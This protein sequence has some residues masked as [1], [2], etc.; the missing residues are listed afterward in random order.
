[1]HPKT[2]KIFAITLAL[3]IIS[4]VAV[5]VFYYIITN[6]AVKLEEQQKIL[7]ENI[8]KESIH[9]RTSHLID[10]T[11]NERA[12][13]ASYYFKNEGDSIDLLGRIENLARELGISLK[14]EALDKIVTKDKKEFIKMSFAFEGKKDLV[15]NFAELFEVLPYHI[16]VENLKLQQQDSGNWV[17]NTTIH[18]SIN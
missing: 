3:A 13:L 18:I 12:R 9:L 8:D 16:K 7:T 5:F 11:K 4:G 1:M 14:T 2:K 10:E 6:Q 17:G 15:F